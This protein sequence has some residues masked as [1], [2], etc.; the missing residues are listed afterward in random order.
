MQLKET[1]RAAAARR[2]CRLA[3]ADLASIIDVKVGKNDTVDVLYPNDSSR[4]PEELILFAV[5]HEAKIE[6]L[7]F[8]KLHV[9]YTLVPTKKGGFR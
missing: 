1:K 9:V 2:L 3:L 6:L 7:Y 8:D 4:I 5:D